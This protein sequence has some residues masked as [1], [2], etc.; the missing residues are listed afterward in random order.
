MNRNADDGRVL[1]QP[2][3]RD[4]ASATRPRALPFRFDTYPIRWLP[5]KRRGEGSRPPL[6]TSD[7]GMVGFAGQSTG[8][9][10]GLVDASVINTPG[11]PYTLCADGVEWVTP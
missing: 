1:A 10:A 9:S 5:V 11:A 3:W 2:V 8:G 4:A 7:A 6:V